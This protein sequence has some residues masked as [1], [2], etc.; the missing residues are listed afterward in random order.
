V[1]LASGVFHNVA[2]Y[3]DAHP[4][5]PYVTL[6]NAT[7][8][9]EGRLAAI[10]RLVQAHRPDVVV[11]ANIA[12]VIGGVARARYADRSLSTLAVMTIHAIQPDFFEDVM[13]DREFIDGVIGTNRLT[14][15]LVHDAG[16]P[17]DRT[18][19][20]PYGVPLIQER[21]RWRQRPAGAPL[22][23][24]YV[25]RFEQ[26]QKRV[27]DIARICD[28]LAQKRIA[29]ELWI[30]GGGPDESVL[31]ESLK[32][33]DSA[34]HVR[35]LGHV[36]AGEVASRVY[37]QVD[38][39]LNPSLWETGPIVAWEAMAHG[40][41][42]ASSRYVGSGLESALVD[43]RNCVLFDIGDAAG[44]AD[45]IGA[46]ANGDYVEQLRSVGLDLISARYSISTSIEK[47][48]NSLL[49][50]IDMGFHSKSKSAYPVPAQG[51]LDRWLG[52][53]RA[54][55][56]RQF[57]RRSFVH[58]DAGSEWPHSYGAMGFDDAAFWQRAAELDTDGQ[59]G[60]RVA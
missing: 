58:R 31:R 54:E 48:S 5:L 15:H 14:E 17:P 23:I 11:S 18:F 53:Q 42:V 51:R 26:W 28:A 36:P 44:A 27:L 56:L 16:Y 2:A 6:E 35:W 34:G 29:F 1:A 13:R 21:D 41:V 3:R 12:D 8:S 60:R 45:K 20:A 30:A 46:L 52:T 37:S 50:L 49:A 19:Y 55:R 10:A 22:R 43:G 9:R 38:V 59:S 33:H 57:A 25:G 40:L 47:F 39:L 7:G 32:R 4:D 24:A